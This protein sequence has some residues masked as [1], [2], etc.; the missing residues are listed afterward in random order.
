LDIILHRSLLRQQEYFS[1][2]P[3]QFQSP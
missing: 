2:H 3:T 1:N